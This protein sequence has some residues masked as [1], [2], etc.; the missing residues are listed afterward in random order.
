MTRYDP[1]DEILRTMDDRRLSRS[2]RK[3]LRRHLAESRTPENQRLRLCA[4]VF[5]HARS[6]MHDH[7]DRALLGWVEDVVAA[8]RAP[9]EAGQAPSRSWFAPWDPLAQ[10]LA[11]IF[12]GTRRSLDAAIYTLTDDRVREAMLRA[13][14]RGV[15]IRIIADD[16]KADDTG[17][18]I[19]AL[20]R[21]GVSVLLDAS[22]GL[23]HHKFALLDDRSLVT[24]S[25]NWTRTGSEENQENLLHTWDRELVARYARA[26]QRMWSD[27]GGH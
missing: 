15:A 16:E 7:R 18:D 8:L 20:R 13:H 5:A 9:P 12:D 1:L 11:S 22:P 23:F 6:R 27:R 21:A 14:H 25:Y 17:S 4:A 3:A 2:E 24:G 10:V 26:F 19:H